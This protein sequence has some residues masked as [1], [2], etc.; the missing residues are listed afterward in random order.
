[1]FS[2]CVPTRIVFGSGSLESLHEYPLPH[3]R[4]LIVVSDGGALGDSFS[5]LERIKAQLSLA[6][7][8]AVIFD[9][10]APYA[11]REAV[12]AVAA[13]AREQNCAGILA[14][15]RSAVVN[16]AKGAA[17]MA[18]NPGD[19]WDYASEGTG[20]KRS[21][22]VPPLPTVC[23]PTAAGNG[24]ELSHDFAVTNNA[25]AERII[26]GGPDSLHPLI[27]LYDPELMLATPAD[28]TA[29]NGF[30]VLFRSAEAFLSRFANPLS[31]M[32]AGT[33]LRSLG[34]YLARACQDGTDLA[35]REHVAF[36]ALTAAQAADVSSNL[37]CRAMANALYAAH[38]D[39]PHGVPGL[40][41]GD[42]F[43]EHLVSKHIEGESFILMAKALGLE[44]AEKPEDFITA[45]RN[46]RDACRMP[47][48]SMADCGIHEEECPA[49]AEKAFATGGR[50]FAAD[51]VAMT[52]DECIAIYR[53][54]FD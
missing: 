36:A 30:D 13:C 45:V 17:L 26:F 46:L 29:Y 49:L 9:L 1:M 42:A 54:S 50:L 21:P 20:G 10:H 53:K 35:A 19:L 15:G 39:L 31:R 5:A 6:G 16:T 25:T 48:F 37:S 51:P 22:A 12:M 43:F 11:E 40:L 7:D 32:Y 38:P 34:C 28:V 2:S 27:A 23:L 33:A 3:G 52:H 18:T 24:A 4:I 14:F 41:I 8:E 47:P 44:M